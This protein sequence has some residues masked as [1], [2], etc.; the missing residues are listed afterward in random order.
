MERVGLSYT[1]MM[2]ARKL[3]QSCGW[4]GAG[5]GGD[6]AYQVAHDAHGE[7]FFFCWHRKPLY[8]V[9]AW[10]PAACRLT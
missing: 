9:S 7:A 10:K 5:A 6:Y 2:E 8:S 1:G 4:G 3:L